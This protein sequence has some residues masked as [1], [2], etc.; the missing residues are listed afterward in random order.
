MRAKAGK[1][2]PF[3]GRDPSLDL[4]ATFPG[5]PADMGEEANS[6]TGVKLHAIHALAARVD[7]LSHSIGRRCFSW[8]SCNAHHAES[9]ASAAE[10][11]NIRYKNANFT[12]FYF[13]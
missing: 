12:V 3:F 13:E 4:R 8:N 7:S 5:S 9:T 6:V 2:L 10:M 1:P 11:Q